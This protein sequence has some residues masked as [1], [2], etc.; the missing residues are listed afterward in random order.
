MWKIPENREISSIKN[1][2]HKND[3]P[4]QYRR[5]LMFMLY[6][7]KLPKRYLWPLHR[8]LISRKVPALGKLPSPVRVFT[9]NDPLTDVGEIIIEM[10]MDGGKT[11]LMK[12]LKEVAFSKYFLQRI[13]GTS[14]KFQP[15]RKFDAFLKRVKSRNKDYFEDIDISDA[16]LEANYNNL[17]VI[18]DKS[19]KIKL[20]WRVQKNRHKNA[21]SKDSKISVKNRKDWEKYMQDIPIDW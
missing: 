11:E 10:D 18:K 14:K 4:V 2:T 17:A 8:Y 1:E 5:D 6:Q 13:A 21:I 9:R 16:D 20:G 7:S 3:L 19:R 12:S 15:I